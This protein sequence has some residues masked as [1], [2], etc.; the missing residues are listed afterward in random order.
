M[1]ITFI[2]NEMLFTFNT[3]LNDICS[4]LNSILSGSYD[5]TL[6]IWN[7]EGE[8]VLT[9]PGHAAPVKCL[10][11]LKQGKKTHTHTNKD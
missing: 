11:W 10:A 3:N 9:I 7:T 8:A 6:R 5:N 2:F 1:L 4:I